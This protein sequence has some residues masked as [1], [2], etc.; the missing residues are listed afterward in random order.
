MALYSE[1][2]KNWINN[3]EQQIKP[4]AKIG[5]S[6]GVLILSVIKNIEGVIAETICNEGSVCW[7][8]VNDSEDKIPLPPIKAKPM[9]KRIVWDPTRRFS[10]DQNGYIKIKVIVPRKLVGDPIAKEF[11]YPENFQVVDRGGEAMESK[12]E[13]DSQFSHFFAIKN[14]KSDDDDN[15]GDNGRNTDHTNPPQNIDITVSANKYDTADSQIGVQGPA[16]KVKEVTQN[17]REANMKNRFDNKNCQIGAQGSKIEVESI[18]QHYD[19]ANSIDLKK[20]TGELETL[21]EELRKR[22]ET[23]QNYEELKWLSE[24]KIEADSDNKTGVLKKLSKVSRWS[25]NIAKEIGIEL[26]AGVI[27][28]RIQMSKQ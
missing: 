7:R 22:A 5:W 6:R 23:P 14:G 27:E 17:K 1:E 25:L 9:Y 19:A 12:C 3:S 4:Y 11:D 15:G 21:I 18:T 20:L 8:F 26:I 13:G 28:R 2:T 16:R 24:A 10:Q